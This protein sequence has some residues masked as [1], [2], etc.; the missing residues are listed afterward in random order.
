MK[1]AA[2]SGEVSRGLDNRKSGLIWGKETV[3]TAA[4]VTGTE[5]L[6]KLEFDIDLSL[7]GS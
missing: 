4:H 7:Q 3:A 1:G 6:T 5:F 2:E